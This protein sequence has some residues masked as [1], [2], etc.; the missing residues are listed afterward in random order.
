MIEEE[1]EAGKGKLALHEASL[2]SSAIV[3]CPPRPP[4]SRTC[5]VQPSLGYHKPRGTVPEG[6]GMT[7]DT[8]MSGMSVCIL[9]CVHIYQNVHLVS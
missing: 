4:F 2:L 5:A 7:D 3:A 9:D 6:P 1:E 8:M